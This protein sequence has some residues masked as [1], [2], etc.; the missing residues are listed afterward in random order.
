MDATADVT[1]GDGDN[2]KVRAKVRANVLKMITL[3]NCVDWVYAYFT[4][5][6]AGMKGRNEIINPHSNPNIQ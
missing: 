5:L 6:E 1:L 3:K 2:L 4:D